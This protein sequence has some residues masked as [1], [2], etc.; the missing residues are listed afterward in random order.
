MSS[1]H[2]NVIA[3]VVKNDNDNIPVRLYD[4]SCDIWI[5]ADGLMLL[6]AKLLIVSRDLHSAE[7]FLKHAWC[8][9]VTAATNVTCACTHI[10]I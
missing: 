2:L 6:D 1:P 10:V 8:H 3:N 5:E 9:D 7:K 4:F